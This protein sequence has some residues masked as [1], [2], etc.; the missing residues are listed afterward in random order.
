MSP[1]LLT[2]V[3]F[4]VVMAVL[5]VLAMWQTHRR[6]LH[7]AHGGLVQIFHTAW[8]DT[9]VWTS[10]TDHSASFTSEGTTHLIRRTSTNSGSSSAL[11]G[12]G[13]AGLCTMHGISCQIELD[14]GPS[15]TRTCWHSIVSCE[16][17][18]VT[19][20]LQACYTG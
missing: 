12:G 3:I 16:L 2:T 5:A 14:G 20:F 7:R 15:R 4:G 17:F 18:V 6:Q 1:E 11:F 9:V 19:A 8:Y 10:L 13:P